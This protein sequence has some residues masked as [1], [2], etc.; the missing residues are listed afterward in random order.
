MDRGTLYEVK[1][2]IRDLFPQF[3]KRDFIVW[4]H[5]GLS[6]G[7]YMMQEMVGNVVFGHEYKVDIISKTIEPVII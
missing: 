5:E 2:K 7:N 6:K 1:A 3:K 4:F